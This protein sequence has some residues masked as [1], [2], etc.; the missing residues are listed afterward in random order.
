MSRIENALRCADETKI[1]LIAD[2][3]LKQ[4]GSVFRECFGA[5]TAQIIADPVTWQAAGQNAVEILQSEGITPLNDPFIF[6][7]AEIHA[8]MKHIETLK[9]SLAKSDAIP[10]AVGSGTVN[11]LTKYASFLCGRSYM[12][13][14]T[15]ASMDGYS[16][17]GASIEHNSAKQTFNCPAPKAVLADLAVI[18]QA[19]V[20]M[21]ASGY[22]D[23]I[24]KI[25]AAADWFLADLLGTEPIDAVALDLVQK[26][27]RLW[28]SEPTGI[29]TGQPQSIENLIEGLVMSGLAM[30]KAKSSRTASGA[31][32]QFSHL[33]DN[34]KHTYRGK[35]PSHGFKVGIGTIATSALYEEVLRLG[36][37]DFD[38]SIETLPE[39]YQTWDQIERTV[40]ESFASSGL[41][42]TALD[43]CRRKFVD[44]KETRHR[45]ELFRDHWSDL[46]DRFKQQ[47]LPAKTV[48]SMIRA[49]G[50][51]SLPEEIG[52]DRSRL[53]ASFRKARLIRCRYNVLDLL[54]DLG[55]WDLA[56]Q[57]F[58]PGGFFSLEKQPPL[59]QN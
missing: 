32:H 46:T 7:S 1:V 42:Q 38:R 30:Q 51:P 21:N 12:I 19:P 52:I 13:A 5:R 27:L 14:G 16:S 37:G 59:F 25:P 18:C 58:E 28:L 44:L 10:V 35:T 33:W 26:D 55:R 24:A 36:K 8:E 15:A 41:A 11:D 4:I 2:N 9:S 49:A 47:L 3:A 17:Y 40:S 53:K 31:E 22:A 45:L 50:A 57:L 56:D 20:E 34:E 48:Q 6:E 23:L 54:S 29:P 39:H 43:Q